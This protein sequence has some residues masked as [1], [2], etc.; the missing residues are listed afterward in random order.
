MKKGSV[1][2]REYNA[3]AYEFAIRN[4]KVIELLQSKLTDSVVQELQ[5]FGIDV[6]LTELDSNGDERACITLKHLPLEYKHLK[7]KRD[8]GLLADS[9]IDRK[10]KHPL[11]YDSSCTEESGEQAYL[12]INE[13]FE[14]RGGGRG[15]KNQ[16]QRLL[17]GDAFEHYDAFVFENKSKYAIADA[18][19]I[20]KTIT[21]DI[22]LVQEWINPNKY[23]QLLP[24][25][26]NAVNQMFEWGI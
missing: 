5:I 25:Y 6:L 12:R 16:L 10:L 19:Q 9:I 1:S 14:T 17:D 22:D 24:N 11:S 18:N 23:L 21:K 26:S 2:L 8:V 7:V 4:P 3:L 20:R 15:G 13:Y